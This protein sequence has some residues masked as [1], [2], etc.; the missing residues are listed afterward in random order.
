MAAIR[1]RRISGRL[2]KALASAPSLKVSANCFL[3]SSEDRSGC[4]SSA[5]ST[6]GITCRTQ[7]VAPTPSSRKASAIVLPRARLSFWTALTE[8]SLKM[9]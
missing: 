7:T 2:T 9:K 6:F 1:V 4:R 3:A 5:I 8:W